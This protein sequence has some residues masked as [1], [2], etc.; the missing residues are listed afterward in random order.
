MQETQVWSLGQEDPLEKEMAAH[1]SILAWEIPRTEEP[2]GL[3]SPG[4]QK[5]QNDWVT[6]NAQVQWGVYR[7]SVADGPSR[8]RSDHPA[9]LPIM[10][11]QLWA[12]C[13]WPP[14]SA[15]T[16]QLC[17]RRTVPRLAWLPQPAHPAGPGVQ[18]LG[19]PPKPLFSNQAYHS[20]G[21][22]EIV[23]LNGIKI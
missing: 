5:S 3:Q 16:Q 1:S 2:G 9:L 17:S 23:L 21:K 14:L 15:S 6:E 12:P 22:I 8:S 10:M 13:F 19:E 18:T 4:S 11:S 20:I 7:E